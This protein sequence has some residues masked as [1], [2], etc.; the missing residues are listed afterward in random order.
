[1]VL[2]EAIKKLKE[3]FGVDVLRDKHGYF[4]AKVD[5]SIIIDVLRFLKNQGFTQ[6]VTI[7]GIDRPQN[8]TIE[9]IYHLSYEENGYG[10]LNISTDVSRERPVIETA[11]FIYNSA[12]IYEREIFDLLGVKFIGHP[13]LKRVLLPE[14]IPKG[15]HPLRKDWKGNIAEL[16]RRGEKA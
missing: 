5:R 9:L 13:E 8:G 3:K 1:L 10:L 15:I 6:L 4:W 2:E 14:D 12:Y 11:Y 7:T 16:K